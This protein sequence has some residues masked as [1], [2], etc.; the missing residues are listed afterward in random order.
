MA[1]GVPGV[2]FPLDK[3]EI[4]I[5]RGLENDICLPDAYASKEHALIEAQPGEQ[6]DGSVHYFLR[7]L[8]STNCTYL[9]NEKVSRS[10]LHADDIVK[11]GQ[12]YFK[13]VDEAKSHP[14]LTAESVVRA[15]G[16]RTA[17]Q[18]RSFSRR[19]RSHQH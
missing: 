5:G 8:K 15:F 13:F 2:K 18:T 17:S 16:S 19:L 12:S 4:R 14:D 9:N 3:R 11:I 6:L 1:N 7:D 10:R